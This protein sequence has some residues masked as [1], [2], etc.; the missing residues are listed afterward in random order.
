MKSKNHLRGEEGSDTVP[1][2]RD[3]IHRGFEKDRGKW[4]EQKEVLCV[5]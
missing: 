4:E 1:G 5:E 3:G 2:G